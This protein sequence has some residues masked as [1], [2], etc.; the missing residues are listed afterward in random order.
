[1]KGGIEPSTG[2]FGFYFNILLFLSLMVVYDPYLTLSNLFTIYIYLIVRC[3]LS[4]RYGNLFNRAVMLFL[5]ISR[6]HIYIFI[7]RIT[8][9]SLHFVWKH[10]PYQWNFCHLDQL[11]TLGFFVFLLRPSLTKPILF[12]CHCR[13]FCVI[14]YLDVIM[15]LTHYTCA[16]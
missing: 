12:L 16:G 7:L 13:V 14:I 8:F 11:W 4:D 3:L 9:T 1:M 15:V 5:L 6:M 10:K 2:G